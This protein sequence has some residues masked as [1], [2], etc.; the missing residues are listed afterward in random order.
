MASEPHGMYMAPWAELIHFLMVLVIGMTTMGPVP[1]DADGLPEWKPANS[2][3][4]HVEL[5]LSLIHI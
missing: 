5:G 2:V 1:L 4:M 3:R